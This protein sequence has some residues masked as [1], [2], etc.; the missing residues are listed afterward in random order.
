V[1]EVLIAI[2]AAGSGGVAGVAIWGYITGQYAWLSISSIA[3]V[4]GVVKP[5]LQVG[6]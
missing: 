3:T 4:L 6:R 1:T 5:I 2:G